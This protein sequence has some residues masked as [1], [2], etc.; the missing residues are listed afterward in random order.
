MGNYMEARTRSRGAKIYGVVD[1]KLGVDSLPYAGHRE[2]GRLWGLALN[3]C[4]LD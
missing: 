2:R 4:E 3:I 1:E